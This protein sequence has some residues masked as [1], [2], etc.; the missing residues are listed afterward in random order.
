VRSLLP[1]LRQ[2]KITR[3]MIGVQV[4]PVPRDMLADFGLKERKGALVVTV[5]GDGPA[6][7]AGVQAGDVIIDMN[8]KPVPSRDELVQTVMALKPGTTV[9][10]KVVRDKQE[11]TL[12]VT[13]GELNLDT[14]AQSPEESDEQTEDTS[15]GFGM[16]LGNLT[17][18]RARRLELPA[19]TTGALIMDVDQS[20]TAY[21]AGL[22][23]G[24]VILQVNR[25]KVE[26]AV[27]AKTELQ[28]IKSG[29]TT[30]LLIWR[31][32]QKIFLTLKKDL[33]SRNFR[34]SRSVCIV[35]GGRVGVHRAAYGHVH[36]AR[37][38]GEAPVRVG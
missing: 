34:A 28:K 27:D 8:G 12:N 22:Q 16:T 18:D 36:D 31:S 32:N 4:Q 9:P 24:D 15:A 7:K 1:S 5:S 29:G 23:A 10:M 11:K 35:R 17:A 20:G 3:G 30:M 37:A 13:I 26:S 14:E 2:G 6:E 25:R 38:R 21:R 33:L 19:G